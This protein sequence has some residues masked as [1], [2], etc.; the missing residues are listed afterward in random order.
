MVDDPR[1]HWIDCDC[2]HL[3]QKSQKE[4]ISDWDDG[5]VVTIC[6]NGSSMMFD[7]VR[8]P[9]PSWSSNCFSVSLCALPSA[10]CAAAKLATAGRV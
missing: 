4:N 2:L 7:I 1:N 9:A 5:M 3:A 6:Y 8:D 10:D